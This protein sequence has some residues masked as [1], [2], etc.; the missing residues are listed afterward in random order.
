MEMAGADLVVAQGFCGKNRWVAISNLTGAEQVDCDL[1]AGPEQVRNRCE[2]NE[3]ARAG[4]ERVR[5]VFRR[6]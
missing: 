6:Q 2:T 5:L 4:T 3:A 1:L